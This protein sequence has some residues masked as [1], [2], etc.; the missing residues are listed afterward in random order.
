M[1]PIIRRSRA[2]AGVTTRLGLLGGHPAVDPGAYVDDAPLRELVE[3]LDVVEADVLALGHL[4]RA[5]PRDEVVDQ[6]RVGH[7]PGAGVERLAVGVRDGGALLVVEH[8]TRDRVD[9][10]GVGQREQQLARV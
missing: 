6:C 10:V 2:S 9:V 4:H 5:E 3:L 7:R 8:A 1:R